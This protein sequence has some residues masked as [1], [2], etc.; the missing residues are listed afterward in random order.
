MTE[1]RDWYDARLTHLQFLALYKWN[2]RVTCD[3]GRTA[4]FSGAG[5]W[6]RFERKHWSDRLQ[7]V[8]KRL[9]CNACKF[10]RRPRKPPRCEKTRDE[11][12]HPLPMPDDREWRKM[13]SR[14]RS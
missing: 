1:T 3:C 5:L 8:P 7:D 14:Y 2:V 11:V 12:T 13:V 10:D 4:V 6:W 9:T